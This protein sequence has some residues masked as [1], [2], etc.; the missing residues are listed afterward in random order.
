MSF[1][2]RVIKRTNELISKYHGNLKR[3]QNK[4]HYLSWYNEGL[5][6]NELQVGKVGE[7]YG[8]ISLL[9][10][11]KASLKKNRP[12]I[13]ELNLLLKKK[14]GSIAT[15]DE[16]ANFIGFIVAKYKPEQKEP[17]KS[18]HNTF[19]ETRIS[20]N[21]IINDN[22][23]DGLDR[24]RNVQNQA[25]DNWVDNN[26]TVNDKYHNKDKAPNT[27]IN[28]TKKTIATNNDMETLR[29]QL[30]LPTVDDWEDL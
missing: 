18:N 19:Q 24:S 5:Y 11:S 13:R 25:L 23:I 2:E 4:H 10:T 27:Q 16:L 17:I 26:M 8:E 22:D 12:K 21:T 3:F 28:S 15:I 7:T 30:N 6:K 9:R 20:A 29:N 14:K 1:E